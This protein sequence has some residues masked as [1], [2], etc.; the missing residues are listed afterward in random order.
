MARKP[1][2]DYP[3]AR[4]HVMN[5][6]IRKEALFLDD[7]ACALFL[8]TLAE[9]PDRFGA[10]IHGFALM[11]DHYHLM[12]EVPRGNLSDVM[13]HVGATYTQAWNRQHAHDGPIFRGRFRNQLVEDDPYEVETPHDT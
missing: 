9:V 5:R 13:K 11:P 2:A 8:D 3:G 6:A 1:R 4:H 10:R 12:V 7:D